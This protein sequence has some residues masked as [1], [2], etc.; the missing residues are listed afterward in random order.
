MAELLTPAEYQ[1]IAQATDNLTANKI[2]KAINDSTA[3]GTVTN[4]ATAGMLSGGPITTT[5]TITTSVATNKLIGRSTAGTGVFE[6]ITLGT[7]LSF[8]GSTLNAAGGGDISGGSSS[9]DGEIARYNLA[10]GK[11]IKA[12]ATPVI[13]SDLGDIT[14]PAARTVFAATFRSISSANTSLLADSGGEVIIND[15]GNNAATAIGID[16]SGTGG[17]FKFKDGA[18]AGVAFGNSATNGFIFGTNTVSIVTN[19]VEKWMVNSSGALNP[20]LDNTY[21]IGNGTVNP[22][23]ITV[24]R[25]VVTDN[26]VDKGGHI[27][28]NQ[29]TSGRKIQLDTLDTNIVLNS[30]SGVLVNAGN[31]SDLAITLNGTGTITMNGVDTHTGTVDTAVTPN[32]VFENGLLMSAS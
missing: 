1:L 17:Y 31:N 5:G 16:T 29:S 12:S 2:Q 15:S 22:R 8:T 32:L 19:G 14:L 4:I 11:V 7:N 20:I 21:D 23:D 24:S 9:T 18:A 25:N 13:V 30:G 28:I 6:A 27:L 10:T 3:T 26:I